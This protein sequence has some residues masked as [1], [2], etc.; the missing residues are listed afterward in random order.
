M[1][2]SLSF[3][4]IDNTELMDIDGGSLAGWAAFATG[5]IIAVGGACL[6]VAALPLVAPVAAAALVGGAVLSGNL[7]VCGIVAT[8]T[9]GYMGK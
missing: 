7:A 4:E 1:V 5:S 3:E 8:A 2:Y 9:L 6:A